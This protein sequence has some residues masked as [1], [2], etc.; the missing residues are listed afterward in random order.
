MFEGAR[1]PMTEMATIPPASSPPPR[2]RIT[3]LIAFLVF[4]LILAGITAA[5]I[6]WLFS[7]NG[8]RKDILAQIR[9]TTGL[10]A[11]SQ[12][13]S[14]FVILPQPHISIEDIRLADP[15]GA[16]R[17]DARYLKGYLRVTSLLRGRLEIAWA[18]LGEPQI[19]IDV[20]GRP[21]PSDSAIGRAAEAKSLSPQAGVADEAPLGVVSLF[22]GGARLTSRLGAD[23]LI[24]GINVTVDWRRL[25]A[26][27]RVAGSLRFR[28][29]DASIAAVV[30]R[31][32]ELLRGGQSPLSLRINGPAL[33]L[34]AEGSLASAP[35]ARFAG[36]VTAAAPSLRKLV[37]TGGYFAD[38][39]APFEDFAVKSD[40]SIGADS[41][42][43]SSLDLKLDGNEYEG[44]LAVIMSGKRPIISGTLAAGSLSLRPFIENRA[45]ALA[46]DGQWT[47]DPFDLD[48]GN[49]ADVDLRVSAARLTLPG[50]DLEDAA[51]S[52]IN[53]KD[54]LDVAL[55]DAKAYQGSLK[56]RAS[57]AKADAG[58][59][60]R[61]SATASDVDFAGVWPN[62]SES[63]RIAGAMSA[64][65]NVESV[66]SNMSELMRNLNGHAQV[67]LDRGV[68]GG[69]NLD[70][71]LRWIDKR[72]LGLAE[73]IRY[74]GTAFD[75]ARLGLRIAGGVAEIEDGATM[76]STS[77]NLG[78]GGS[79]DFGERALNVHATATGLGG[80]PKPGREPAKFAFDIAGSWDDIALIP[81]A[82]SLIRQSG[83][84]A[85][86]FS[87]NHMDTKA[88]PA[89]GH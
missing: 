82:R 30:E 43:F 4:A 18:T 2:R 16:L 86:L 44:A 78:F 46:R 8:L 32:T 60:M 81:D 22:N 73:D 77:F 29:Q 47:R 35:A 39:P 3:G 20:D 58:V 27:A 50:I 13:Q 67:A 25:G 64:T 52:L 26:A 19:T 69:V 88:A 68:L 28:G 48:S 53:Q 7:T 62:P 9:Q 14:V 79:I 45:P 75:Q 76:L 66:G 72:P 89:E 40:A 12:G 10:V 61:A 87:P 33:L 36:R 63:W 15:S 85:P 80:A 55:I 56:G 42:S 65:G 51:F 23:V 54:R 59:E 71:A 6:P 37:E 83:A 24:D 57:F 5:A 74:G 17:I 21:M 11:V 41:A 31:P 49:F 84:A 38:L 1:Y 34:S 70:Q